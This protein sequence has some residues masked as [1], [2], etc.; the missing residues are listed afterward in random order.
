MQNIPFNEVLKLVEYIPITAALPING[1]FVNGITMDSPFYLKHID[2]VA[3]FRDI[4]R[5]VNMKV[6]RDM[7][8]EKLLAQNRHKQL[9]DIGC[10]YPVQ[11]LLFDFCLAA[12]GGDHLDAKLYLSH[13][14]HILELHQS[15]SLLL[16]VIINE[17]LTYDDDVRELLTLLAKI[18]EPRNAKSYVEIYGYEYE[19][20][21]QIYL[22]ELEK[23]MY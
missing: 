9:L 1:K 7:R 13:S 23:I 21:Y 4:I 3:T 15:L 8:W 17:K 20:R 12:L 14:F 19:R 22:Y 10:S 11:Y 5:V 18:C 6:L 2:Y 16:S